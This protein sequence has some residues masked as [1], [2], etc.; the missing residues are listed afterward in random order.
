M[1]ESRFEL[2][3]AEVL[4]LFA[5]SGAL[6]IEALSR[7]A[8]HATFVEQSVPAVAVLRTNLE[9]SKFLSSAKILRASIDRGLDQLAASEARFDGVLLDPPY[10]EELVPLTLRRIDGLGL[11]RSGGWVLAEHHVDDHIDGDYGTLQ[12][13]RSRRYGKTGLALFFE[14]S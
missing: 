4:D 7:G 5:G 8:A 14:R 10:G 2:A 12:L 1:L 6:G 11:V 13:T 3:G 9:A